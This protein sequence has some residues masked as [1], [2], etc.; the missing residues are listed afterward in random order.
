MDM[1]LPVRR[2][3]FP[4]KQP[5][6]DHRIRNARR[7]RERMR[8][9]LLEAVL[10]VYPGEDP[11][12]P[13]VIDDVIRHAGV[14]R[15]SFYKYFR[16][17]EEAVAELGSKF[18]DELAEAYSSMYANVDDP[19]I[20]AATGFQLFLARAYLDS[21]WGSFVCHLNHL[22]RNA[23]MLRRIRMDLDAGLAASIFSIDDMDVALDLVIGAKIEGVRHLING[24]GSRRYIEAMATM[25]L[26]SLGL[27][28]DAAIS[29]V[30]AASNRLHREAPAQLNWWR[31]F[32]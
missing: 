12:A 18:A 27:A 30:R 1:V 21:R 10:A 20:R 6:E 19:A 15:G 31:T 8:T 22:N 26:K 14:S 28:P 25:I 17:L 7:R 11:S 16:S 23:G 4:D 24:G 2:E 3:S 5:A 9:Q 32:D 13:A 29:V